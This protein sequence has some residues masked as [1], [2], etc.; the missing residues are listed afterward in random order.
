MKDIPLASESVKGLKK[1]LDVSKRLVVSEGRALRGV[2]G[3]SFRRCLRGGAYNLV[4][5]AKLIGKEVARRMKT[6]GK[7]AS[8]LYESRFPEQKFRFLMSS[9]IV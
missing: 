7:R 2:T 9:P 4:R 1:F 5:M 3:R 8:S 6:D